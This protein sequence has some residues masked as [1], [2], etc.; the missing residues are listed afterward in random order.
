MAALLGSGGV[1]VSGFAVWRGGVLAGGGIALCIAVDLGAAAV[2]GLGVGGVVGLCLR[3]VAC[4]VGVG[5]TVAVG[6]AAAGGA[7]GDYSGYAAAAR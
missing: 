3:G 5:S 2:A 1:V 4:R 7:A 6:G